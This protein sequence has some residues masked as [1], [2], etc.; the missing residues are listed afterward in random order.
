M[1]LAFTIGQ[2]DQQNAHEPFQSLQSRV[3][4]S[5][6]S[7]TEFSLDRIVT[8]DNRVKYTNQG[9]TETSTDHL[10]EVFHL[11][12]QLNELG[13]GSDTLGRMQ[14]NGRSFRDALR[15]CCERVA[16]DFSGEPLVYVELGPEPIKTGYIVKTLLALGVT[17]D[18][19]I[20]VD[21]NPKSAAPMRA[22]LENILPDTPL[23]FVTAPF[24]EFSLE[25]YLGDGTPRALVTMLGFQEGN[26]DPYTVNGWLKTIARPGD[27]LLSESQL[28]K[29]GQIDKIPYFY[30]NPAMQRFSRIAFEQSIDRA[31]PT[32][33]RF[34]LLPVPFRDGE[35]AQVAILGE[36]FSNAISGR[37]LHVSNF[38][39][40]LTLDQYRHYRQ[41]GGHFEITGETFTDDE[42][43]HFQLSRR[44]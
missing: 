17:F 13:I 20:A 8:Q 14:E 27:L 41:H 10:D 19:Y 40:K 24:E 29:A 34:F 38:C 3:H 11:M 39:L 31:M 18:R 6:A 1:T 15:H 9:R 4:R 28:Y 30:A 23:D 25:R 26:D 36:E 32:L 33:N 35:T 42:T 22:A 12:R 37:S 21:I 5:I 7:H 16:A 43:L 2:A 44:V